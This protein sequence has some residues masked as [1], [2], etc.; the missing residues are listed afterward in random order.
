MQDLYAV[1]KPTEAIEFARRLAKLHGQIYPRDAAPVFGG[2]PP[3]RPA[4]AAADIEEMVAR[5]WL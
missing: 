2:D 4:D 5:P 3:R 1:S